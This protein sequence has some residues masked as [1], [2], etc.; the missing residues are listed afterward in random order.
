MWLWWW[1]VGG[2]SLLTCPGR[3]D[4]C[5]S[6]PGTFTLLINCV[7]DLFQLLILCVIDSAGVA[8]WKAC[9]EFGGWDLSQSEYFPCCFYR[10][11]PETRNSCVDTLCDLRHDVSSS[12]VQG[13]DEYGRLLRRTLVRYVNLTSLLILRSVSTAVCKRF[14]T[15]DHVVEAGESL[16]GWE[17]FCTEA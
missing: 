13:K 5:S 11:W 10:R 4:S 9:N 7:S 6:S 17:Q 12:C 2:I 8:C 1:I 15:I 16:W 14:P 3:T